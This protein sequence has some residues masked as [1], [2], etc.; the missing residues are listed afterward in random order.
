MSCTYA[1]FTLLFLF[2]AMNDIYVRFKDRGVHQPADSRVDITC[3]GEKRRNSVW[4]N[5][6]VKQGGSANITKYKRRQRQT[7]KSRL[8]GHTQTGHEPEC[9]RE[10]PH[11]MVDRLHLL[12]GPQSCI[13]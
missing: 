5:R 3:T 9:L 7:M 11:Q 12:R 13:T 8:R 4:D 6:H 2:Q 10:P 1:C